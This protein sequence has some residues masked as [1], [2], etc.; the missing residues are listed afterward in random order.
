MVGARG[1]DASTSGRRESR[2]C[3]GDQPVIGKS[4]VQH[5]RFGNRIVQ[6]VGEPAG[7]LG[8]S[9]PM[10][11]VIDYC[12]HE[13]GYT[14]HTV[15]PK[16]WAADFGLVERVTTQGAPVATRRSFV[17]EAGKPGLE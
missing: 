6:L 10:R 14:R 15:T 7:L 13:R 8:A 12:R 4:N 11:W 5:L 17:V 2:F 1:G 9:L 3:P 16:Q